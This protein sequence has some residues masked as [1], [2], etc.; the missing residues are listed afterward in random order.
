MG[1]APLFQVDA[2]CTDAPFS[3]NPAAVVLL[4]TTTFP[5][6]DVL[7]GIAAS[8]NLSETAFF[9]PDAPE[10]AL[11][12][13]TPTVEVD[14]CGHA[15]L[16]GG[17][18]ALTKLRPEAETITFHSASGPLTV[19]RGEGE[20]LSLGLPA[21]A[22]SP[23][24]PPPGAAEALGVVLVDWQQAA[25]ALA[26]TADAEAVQR[27]DVDL[28]FIAALPTDGL[29]LTAPGAG[30]VDFV[31]RYFAPHAGIDEDPVT[32]SA[33]CTLAPYWAGRLDRGGAPLSAHQ[34]SAR[35]GALTCRHLG[36]RVVLEGRARPFFQGELLDVLDAP[37]WRA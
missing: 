30:D 13:F 8:N 22:P 29:I 15:T 1:A 16:A 35:G 33:H 25:K 4:P 31:S 2:F 10:P 37:T 17:W 19:R 23:V 12:W 27:A 26:V 20:A 36:D 11:R 34:L 18:V 3:G 7:L 6:D 28:D 5:P 21:R 32:G 9:C 24:D 14:L